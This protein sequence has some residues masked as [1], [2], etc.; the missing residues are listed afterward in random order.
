MDDRNDFKAVQGRPSRQALGEAARA[1]DAALVERLLAAGADPNACVAPP[2]TYAGLTKAPADVLPPF[3]VFLLTPLAIA[4]I[5]DCAPIVEALLDAGADPRI[6]FDA[7]PLHPSFVSLPPIY[8]ASSHKVCSLLLAAGSPADTFS[9]L[10]RCWGSPLTRTVEQDIPEG[11]K[12]R[13][14]AE[15]VRSGADVNLP[16]K[17]SGRSP[18][19][20]AVRYGA[21]ELVVRRLLEFG[22][23][24]DLPDDRGVPPLS[25]AAERSDLAAARAL[26][27]AGA[28]PNRA[29][30]GGDRPL[31]Q[32]ANAGAAES[33][34]MVRLLLAFGADPG[35]LNS[36]RH[37]P[38][39][40]AAALGDAETCELLLD[41][42]ADPEA[43]S[44]FGEKPFDM[45]G[46]P[47]SRARIEA[48]LL[49]R[50]ERMEIEELLTESGPAR[51]APPRS[52]L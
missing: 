12:A 38:L 41:A 31:H 4:A 25:V 24:P 51:P 52:A 34:E 23:D 42:G 39:H 7:T 1:S 22:A 8:L 43:R 30:P 11:E 14:V 37:S 48:L 49:A 46:H 15:L 44:L 6:Y 9:E 35:A 19:L 29:D 40:C 3:L 16:G 45:A 13:I 20:E 27:E 33:P 28:D 10:R 2:E 32:A 36:T 18:L 17:D 26:L 21:G 5:K 47:T 50:R